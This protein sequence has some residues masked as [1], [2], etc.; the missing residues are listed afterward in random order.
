MVERFDVCVACDLES[1]AQILPDRDAEFVA[2]LG[3]TEKR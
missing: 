1:A 3:E 2:G